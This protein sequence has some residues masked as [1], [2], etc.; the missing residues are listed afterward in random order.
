MQTIIAVKDHLCRD[1]NVR[2]VGHV[3][4]VETVPRQVRCDIL[5]LRRQQQI[6]TH[7]PRTFLRTGRSFLQQVSAFVPFIMTPSVSKA[8]DIRDS[9]SSLSS[10][11]LLAGHR[12]LPG[13]AMRTFDPIYRPVAKMV[14]RNVRE[15]QQHTK[16]VIDFIKAH[17]YDPEK[18]RTFEQD[19]FGV[20]STI[21]QS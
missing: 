16:V 9:G 5:P 14:E 6:H 3:I 21:H 4:V 10:D 2:R 13:Q 1:G 7:N 12:R 18:K 15:Y 17:G 8:V 19:A 11:K 20:V